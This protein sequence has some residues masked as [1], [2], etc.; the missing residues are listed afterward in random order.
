MSIIVVE[1][2]HSIMRLLKKDNFGSKSE[3]YE[4]IST[5]QM[6]FNEIEVDAPKAPVET[7]QISHIRKKK[8][9]GWT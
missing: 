4:N 1:R 9:R 2:L 5:E 3:R 6:V 7:E 8:G